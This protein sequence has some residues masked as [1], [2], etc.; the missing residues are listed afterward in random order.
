MRDERREVFVTIAE[1]TLWF[2]LGIL[3]YRVLLVLSSPH[4]YQ[5]YGVHFAGSVLRGALNNITPHSVN[6]NMFDL[7]GTTT[8][9]LFCLQANF[10]GR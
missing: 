4:S 8:N 3:I 6:Q 9:T 1:G 7:H 2:G 10:W 5:L